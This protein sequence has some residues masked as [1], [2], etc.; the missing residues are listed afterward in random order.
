VALVATSTASAQS[1]AALE[2]MGFR[3][4]MTRSDIE[5]RVSSLGGKWSC[6]TS[7]VDSRFSECRGHINPNGEGEY[8]LTGSLVGGTTAVLLIVGDVDDPQLGQWVEDLSAR[9][10]QVSARLANTQAMWQWVRERRMIRVTTR[11]EQGTRVVSVS[12]V[13]GVILDNLGGG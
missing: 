3:P 7:K 13:D 10:G 9:Y 6:T 1:K 5:S 11:I 2:F 12:L 8:Q 4:G